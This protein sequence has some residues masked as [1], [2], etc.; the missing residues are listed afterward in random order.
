[1]NP[2]CKVVEPLAV[3]KT[4]FLAPRVLAG[5]VAKTDVELSTI[6]EV[7]ATPPN[8]ICDVLVKKVPKIRTDLPPS[9]LPVPAEMLEMFGARV[10]ALGVRGVS[11]DEVGKSRDEKVIFV[12]DESL[13]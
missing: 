9:V 10:M 2:F 1:M 5:V 7:A 8:V 4:T 13:R 11:L 3:V 6:I 12:A